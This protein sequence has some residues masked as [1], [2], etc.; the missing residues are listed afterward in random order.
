MSSSSRA[1]ACEKG[2]VSTVECRVSSACTQEHLGKEGVVVL[3]CEGL[4]HVG[5]RN[6]FS[7]IAKGE[8][9][10]TCVGLIRWCTWHQQA[11][12]QHVQVC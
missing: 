7:F 3:C 6:V 12:A 2:D 4:A 1:A 8:T 5:E 9:T 11:H 10:S